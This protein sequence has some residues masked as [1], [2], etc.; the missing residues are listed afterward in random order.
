MCNDNNWN[1]NEYI[2]YW[3][4]YLKEN[5]ARCDESDLERKKYIKQLNEIMI[6]RYGASV[7]IELNHVLQNIY[8][9]P[10][11]RNVTFNNRKVE[12]ISFLQKNF[13]VNKDDNSIAKSLSN[14]NIFCIQ[15]PPGTGKTTTITEI[16]LQL[17]KKNKDYR[18]LICS[19][20]HVAVDNALLRIAEEAKK[21]RFS[22]INICRYP[23]YNE[24]TVIPMDDTSSF[25]DYHLPIALNHIQRNDIELAR[26]VATY[27]KK[28]NGYDRGFEKLVISK[29]NILGITCNQ[30][31]RF[32]LGRDLDIPYDIAII[33]EVSK[34]TFPEIIIPLN[35]SRKVIL[36]GDPMQLPPTFCREEMEIMDTLSSEQQK[37]TDYI[38]KKSVIDR[39]FDNINKDSKSFLDTQYRMS[40]QIGDIVS[41]LFYKSKLKNG[42][43]Y[44]EPNSV[45]W[46]DYN[47]KER[48]PQKPIKD[49]GVLQNEIEASIIVKTIQERFSKVD[50]KFIAIIT[51]YIKQK[52]YI[53]NLLDQ[54]NI[55]NKSR[56]E[57]NTIDA[58][59]GRE[60]DVVFI[61]FVRNTG[62]GRF[63]SDLRRVNVAISRARD[64]VYFVGMTQYLQKHLKELL[65]LI[66]NVKSID[67]DNFN[68]N[69]HTPKHSSKTDDYRIDK[70][71]VSNILVTGAF[72]QTP[73]KQE[74]IDK[75]VKEYNENKRLS[76]YIIV[77]DQNILIDG[78]GRYLAYVDLQL[79]EIEVIRSNTKIE[80][81]LVTV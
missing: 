60:A 61:S 65:T 20:T 47:T 62:S 25:N 33:D 39:V 79:D 50:D 56:Y 74:K 54:K 44:N 14:S 17:L 48:F 13:S 58:Y 80:Q 8:N 55:I 19:E 76:K 64:K 42:R 43:K 26:N 10:Q 72:K 34:A 12:E 68:S 5:I 16:V 1:L 22:D 6:F 18:I 41:T 15:G 7:N 30:L 3:I 49:G 81:K 23:Q 51:P 29:M 70:I 78:Y 21:L 63:F 57:V 32:E 4:Q 9:N 77:N 45:E 37:R 36:V 31:A 52:R 67:I 2:E 59:Q 75:F 40:N 46:L 35:R 66:T 38:L 71:K 73:P 69:I 53:E 24:S 28:S 27:V 11:T